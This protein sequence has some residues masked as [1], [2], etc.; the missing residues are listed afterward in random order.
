MSS[1]GKR[2]ERETI[3]R[4]PIRLRLRDRLRRYD[5]TL[6]AASLAMGRNK[7]YLQQYVDRGVPAVLGYRDSEALA[8]PLGC[9]G[10]DLRH[11]TVPKRRPRSPGERLHGSTAHAT[12]ATPDEDRQDSNSRRHPLPRATTPGKTKLH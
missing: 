3:R 7:T 9:D 11:E 4:D 12:A 2:D 1:E 10:G 5:F 8:E 6:A